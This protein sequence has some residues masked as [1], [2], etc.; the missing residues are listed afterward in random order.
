MDQ[1]NFCLLGTSHPTFSLRC[2]QW[3][4]AHVLDTGDLHT[5]VYTQ[6][7][8]SNRCLLLG[9]SNLWVALAQVGLLD[10]IRVTSVRQ[11]PSRVHLPLGVVANTFSPSTT[12][13]EAECSP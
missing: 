8:P 10:Q 13:A 4:V 3:V 7:A 1:A 6:Q 9:R 5:S 11:A 12:E 2:L